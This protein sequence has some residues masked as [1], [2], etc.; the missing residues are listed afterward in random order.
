MYGVNDNI[1][2][3]QN[4]MVEYHFL[5]SIFPTT[6][7]VLILSMRDIEQTSLHE[8]APPFISKMSTIN[9]LHLKHNEKNEL[10]VPGVG[11]AS[12][13]NTHPC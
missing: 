1:L 4:D 7:P 6:L 12:Q 8:G 2:A 3:H 13:Y 11:L 10:Y 9:I 5:L